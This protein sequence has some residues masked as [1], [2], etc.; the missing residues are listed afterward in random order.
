MLLKDL[1]EHFVVSD[2]EKGKYLLYCKD[3]N[4]HGRYLARQFYCVVEKVGTTKFKIVPSKHF[5]GDVHSHIFHPTNFITSLGEKVNEYVKS[6]PFHSDTY[7]PTYRDNVFYIYA[8]HEYLKGIGFE[9]SKQHSR[10]GELYELENKDV[11]GKPNTVLLGI[12]GIDMLDNNPDSEVTVKIHNSNTHWM[13]LKCKKDIIDIIDTINNMLLPLF[14]GNSIIQF[15]LS[16]KLTSSMSSIEG[17]E[18][19]SLDLNT[20]SIN[21]VNYKQLLIEKL[22][23]MLI[24]LKK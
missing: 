13:S 10:D 1:K 8:C 20:Y 22:E 3:E 4:T 18:Q 15:K 23:N 17:L 16:N 5:N 11:Y 2:F 24:E 7:C 21:K 14:F 12:Y 19:I 6:L 9:N